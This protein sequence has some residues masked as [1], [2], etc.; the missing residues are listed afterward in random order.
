MAE[1]QSLLGQTVS[2]YRI[3]EKLGVGGMGV[4]YKAEDTRLHRFVA[5]KFLPPEVAREAHALA[6]F[7][8]EA[9]TA[10]GLN[11]PHICTIYDIGEQDGQN[12]IAMELLEGQTL[13]ARINGRPLPLETFLDLALQTAD[14]LEAAH[15]SGIVHRDIKPSNIFVTTRGEIKLA[16]FG[17]AKHLRLETLETVDAPTLSESLTMRGQIVGTIVYMSP[18]QAQDKD[19]DARSDIFSFGAVMYEMATGRQAFGGESGAAVIAEILRGEPKSMRDL[20]P[21]TPEELQRIVSKA[22]EK[23]RADRYQTANDLMVDLRRLKRAQSDPAQTAARSKEDTSVSTWLRAKPVWIPAIAA[24]TVLAFLGVALMVALN[25]GAPVPGPLDSQQLTFSNDLKNGPVVTDGTRLYF[26]SQG[27]SVEMSVTGGS[28]VPI[29]ASLTGMTI[30]DISPDASEVLALKQDFNDQSGRGSIWTVPVLGGYPRKLGNQMARDASWSPDGRSIVYADLSSVLVSD[31]SGANLEEIWNAKREVSGSP[32]FSPDSRRIRVTVAG[33][34]LNDP[35]RIW[36]MNMDGS[37]A[38][39]LALDWPSDADQEAGQ[40]TPDG[41]HFIFTSSREGLNSV[42]EVVQPPWFEFWKKPRAVR[43]SAG[44]ID[45]LGVT[46]S[47][48]SAGLFM[49]GRIPAGAMQAYDSKQRRFVP[50]LGGLP[51]SIFVLSPDKQWMVYSDYPRHFLWRSKLDGSEKLQLTDIDSW[52]PQ[53]SPD[54]K[55][56]AFSDIKEIYTVSV[57]G[58]DPEKLTSDGALAVA[59]SWAPDGKSIFF[60]DFPQPDRYKGLKV[61]NLATRKTAIIPGAADFIVPSWSPNGQYMAATALN[62]LR[63]VLYSAQSR[64]WKDLKKFEADFGYWIWSDDSKSLY[65]AKKEAELGEAPGIYRLTIADGKWELSANFDGLTIN[66]DGSEGFPCL[67]PD[68]RLAIMNDNSVV[69]I[70]STKWNKSSS[71]H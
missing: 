59:P 67:T 61:V 25:A 11:H 31:S 64:T 15:K 56:I 42:Y 10:S 28:A 24:I 57:D 66:S 13:K 21:E 16:D 41:K 53:W 5:L 34:T 63:M 69:Q 60:N 48:D 39:P 29:R 38:H 55:S 37:N 3:I 70:Y 18:E 22:I 19:V 30:L 40:W 33:R 58:G 20:D 17:L 7:E 51:A 35:T 47:R 52:M 4:V 2:H 50:Y 12:F 44:Q 27:Q 6:R 68:G 71:A 9:Q 26:Q 32:R 43:L 36:E 46:P 54:S 8:R 14:A 23:D 49:I 45:V 65:V 1:S 62:P